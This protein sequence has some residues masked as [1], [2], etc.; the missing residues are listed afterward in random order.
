MKNKL[1]WRWKV[2]FIVKQILKVKNLI[3]D[4]SKNFVLI[5]V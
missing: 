3:M 4:V 1:I 5:F 2:K